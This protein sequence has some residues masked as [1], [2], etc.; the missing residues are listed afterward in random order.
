MLTSPNNQSGF[1]LIELLIAMAVIGVLL[2]PLTSTFTFSLESIRHSKNRQR[3]TMLAKDCLSRL[4]STVE[5]SNLPS[6]GGSIQCDGATGG[7]PPFE[8]ADPNDDIDYWTSVSTAGNT[9]GVLIKEV[10]IRVRFSSP[11]HGSGACIT[12]VDC[13]GTA[14]DFTTLV[15]Q[16]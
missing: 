3:A 13:S 7:S 5:F 4:R 1:S 11:F 15:S 12:N 8:F 10:N 9:G 16:R 2:I 6:A 14:W